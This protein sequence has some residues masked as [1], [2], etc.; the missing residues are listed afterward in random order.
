MLQ[1]T[2]CNSGEHPCWEGTRCYV[3]LPCGWVVRVSYI[4]ALTLV[5][6]KNNSERHYGVT[7]RY[8]NGLLSI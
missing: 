2:L 5:P 8:L 1:P 3:A 6:C 7:K 4:L